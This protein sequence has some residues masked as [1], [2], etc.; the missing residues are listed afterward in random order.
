MSLSVSTAW[1]ETVA[2]ARGEGARLF[3]LAFLLLALPA[4]ILQAIAPVTAPGRL[5]EPGFWLLLVPAVLAAGLIGALAICRLA[6]VPGES[7]TA[8]IGGGLRG[9]LPL[10]GAALIAGAGGLLLI[11][12]GILLAAAIGSILP[13]LAALAV[14][15]FFWV[16]LILLTAVAA[17]EPR[18]PVAL[19]R[20]GWALSA[21]SFWR[22][23]G[24]LL[25][26][27]TLSL[28]ALIAAGA[29]GGIA[30]RLAA[31]QPQPGTPAL[32][33]VLLVSALL[34]AAIGGLFTAFLARLYAQLAEGRPG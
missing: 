16:R 28:V 13:G 25:V 32:L 6:L 21:G 26:T 5:P 15:V 10:L 20:R 30:V 2:L 23:L 18:G 29:V 33:L 31:G 1:D 7:M 9:V 8:A 3:A 11:A 34:Q 19:V 17:A 12:A 22:L 4:A 24:A 27:A 14:F